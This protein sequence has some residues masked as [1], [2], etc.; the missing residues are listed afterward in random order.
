MRKRASDLGLD[1]AEVTGTGPEGRVTHADLDRH[2]TR[3][4][5]PAPRRASDG[6]TETRVI[7]L[8]RKIAEQMTRAH[9]AIPAIT[10]VEEVD[11]TELERLRAKMKDERGEARARLTL[12]PF[13]IRAMDLSRR[14]AP[15]VNA[16]YDDVEGVLREFAAVH[17]GVATQTEKGLMVPVMRHAEACSLWDMA[18]EIAR[19]AEGA[20]AGKLGREELGGST[21]TITSLGALGAV[22]STPIINHPEV[23]I[24]GVN[25]KAIRP[26]WDGN[27]FAPREVMNLSA[28]FDH[29]VVD[30]WDA[31]RFVARMKEL[32]EV[33]ALL[34]AAD[35]P[36]GPERTTGEAGV[37]GRREG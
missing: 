23:A 17:V 36:G 33:P 19:L 34:F 13:L 22:A 29:R 11:V 10:I 20:R 25:R 15:Q 27:R 24:V 1:L 30:G 2:L 8:R 21:V 35:A 37:A 16:H 31:A 3:G 32:L 9:A 5:A 26:V 7:G 4:A 18:A 6:V 28:S 14:V 12:L